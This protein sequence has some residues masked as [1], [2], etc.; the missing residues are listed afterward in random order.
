LQDRKSSKNRNIMIV[1]FLLSLLTV[2]VPTKHFFMKHL[3]LVILAVLTAMACQ[4]PTNKGFQSLVGLHFD[5][6][7]KA[8]LAPEWG[9]PDFVIS[10]TDSTASY[11]SGD[12]VFL[13]SYRIKQDSI[14]IQDTF[15]RKLHRLKI[16]NP[17]SLVDELG[18]I[19]KKR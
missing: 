9:G 13:C 1:I 12:M 11:K 17:D 14:F 4:R 5:Q 10:E 6:Q 2:I 8:I 19:W 3:Q 18:L 7:T 16:V 15:S